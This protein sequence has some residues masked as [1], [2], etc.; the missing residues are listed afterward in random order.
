M[1]A[2][3]RWLRNGGEQHL[4]ARLS[5]GAQERSA[6]CRT[7]SGMSANWRKSLPALTLAVVALGGLPIA[8][9]ADRSAESP[10]YRATVTGPASGRFTV[11][12]A[13]FYTLTVT[14]PSARA[15]FSAFEVASATS[16]AFLAYAYA[17]H[18]GRVFSVQQRRTADGEFGT[19]G[20]GGG[21]I[22]GPG[23]GRG[24][25]PKTLEVGS[26][27][28]GPGNYR[29]TVLTRERANVSLS[30]TGPSQRSMTLHLTHDPAANAVMETYQ[31]QD[32]AQNSLRE[33]PLH[34]APHAHAAFVVM[35][36]N[37]SGNTSVHEVG[38]C[39]GQ[40]SDQTQCVANNAA[41]DGETCLE[42]QLAFCAVEPSTNN[43]STG[44][45]DF[46]GVTQPPA[47]DAVGVYSVI[48]GS[49]ARQ[50]IVA[51]SLP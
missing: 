25:L 44:E 51:V 33:L 24:R 31:G 35:D 39:F 42:S 9:A 19:F 34:I 13:A 36:Q 48:S 3:R 7:L 12:S 26:F 27:Q 23:P 16:D 37:W 38:A 10:R 2:P 50:S 5:L 21:A 49:I 41:T 18:S 8:H 14:R 29:L 15:H 22:G 43:S 28:L 11:R 47:G 6:L 4:P 32:A 46:I 1:L 30:P 17:D 40:D 45:T 20:E